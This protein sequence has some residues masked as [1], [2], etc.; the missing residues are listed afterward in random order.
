LSGAFLTSREIFE[1]P[2]WQNIVEFRLFFLIYG[3]AIFSEEGYKQGNVFIGKGQWLRCEAVSA[4]ERFIAGKG[5]TF[6]SPVGRK[7]RCRTISAGSDGGK[8]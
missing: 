2:I 5:D 6:D 3:K 1:N 7:Q 4:G 8:R